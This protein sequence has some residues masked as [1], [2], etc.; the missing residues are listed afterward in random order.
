MKKLIVVSL[1]ALV[2][3]ATLAEPSLA[4]DGQRVSFFDRLFG[5][6]DKPRVRVQ[7][8][9]WWEDKPS[10]SPAVIRPVKVKPK[11]V[12]KKPKVVPVAIDPEDGENLGL[13]NL[14]YMPPKLVS[15]YLN[16][17]EKLDGEA[18]NVSAIRLILADRTTTLRATADVR[19]A[20]LEYY[21][22]S[23]FKPL[24]T[25]NGNINARG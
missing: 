20:V 25:E 3:F 4:R 17:F 19:K 21:K 9:A 15:M 14:N 2:G 11:Q 16:G 7:K 13:G 5:R 24:W 12:A 10:T 8:R 6:F 23:G 22:D 1:T 18:T